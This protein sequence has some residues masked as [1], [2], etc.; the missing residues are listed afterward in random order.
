MDDAR[1]KE[2]LSAEAIPPAEENARKEAINL[3]RAAFDQVQG[4]IRREAEQSRQGI[5][6]LGRLIGR[7]RQRSKGRAMKRMRIFWGFGTITMLAFVSV[8]AVILYVET[9]PV[10]TLERVHTAVKERP[11]TPPRPE[12]KKKERPKGAT[13]IAVTNQ[14]EQAEPMDTARLREELRQRLGTP[15][16]GTARARLLELLQA[17]QSQ[18]HYED[19]GR[20]QFESVAE[21]PVRRV[22]EDPVST[23]SIDVDTAAY[24]FVRRELNRGVL[25]QKDA[26]RIEE[27]VNYFH[28]A[29]PLPA[30]RTRPFAPSVTVTPSPWKAGRG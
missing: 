12:A 18:Q 6:L 29:Y 25:P 22:V 3:A 17:K 27:L 7:D 14:G 24:A 21:N 2:A 9:M 16:P 19:V 26:V 8:A 4:E 28:Y 1:L 5:G 11:E 23:F 30:E 15:E 13:R 10:Q 20:D